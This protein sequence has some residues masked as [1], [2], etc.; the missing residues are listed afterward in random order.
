[1]SGRR[2]RIVPA[3]AN[4]KHMPGRSYWVYMIECTGGVIYTGIAVDPKARFR[5]HLAGKGARFTRMRK[6]LRILGMQKFP[7]RGSALR[8]EKALK[9]LIPREKRKWA[10][11]LFSPLEDRLSSRRL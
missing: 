11:D 1:M 5:E 6:P 2:E 10:R 4:R 7:D 8:A 3:D 9:K